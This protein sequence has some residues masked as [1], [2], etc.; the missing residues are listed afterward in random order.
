MLLTIKERILLIQ[1]L[2]K[3]GDIFTQRIVRDLRSTIGL[4]D[5]DW[6]NYDIVKS[7]D[8]RVQWNPIKDVGVEYSFGAKATEL[9]VSALNDLSKAKKV[10]DDYLSLFDKFL[11]EEKPETNVAIKA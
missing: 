5:D 6:K 7:D 9:I 1:S 8:G 10:N 3:E 11:P 4:S 2:P